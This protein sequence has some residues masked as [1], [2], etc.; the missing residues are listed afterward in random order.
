MVSNLSGFRT[1]AKK[2]CSFL[3][4]RNVKAARVA[5]PL[6]PLDP[7]TMTLL[8]DIAVRLVSD[9]MLILCVRVADCVIL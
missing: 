3:V 6:D 5:F 1:P 9:L 2:A 4:W 7:I 8:D